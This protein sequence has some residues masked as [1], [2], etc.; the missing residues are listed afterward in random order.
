MTLQKTLFHKNKVSLAKD[1]LS[2]E[3]SAFLSGVD[4]SSLIIHAG[5]KIA[6]FADFLIQEKKLSSTITILCGKGNNGADGYSAASYL[7]KKG[8]RVQL[9]HAFD[10][11]E[12]YPLCQK[13]MQQFQKKGGHVHFISKASDIHFEKKSLIIDALLGIGFTGAL[14][15]LICEIVKK[16]NRSKETILAVDVPTGLNAN[17]GEVKT[18]AIKAYATITFTTAKKGFFLQQGY[19][20]VGKIFVEKIGLRDEFFQKIKPFAYLFNEKALLQKIPPIVRKRQKYERGSIVGIA[21]SKSMMGAAYLSGLSALR[22][23][24]GIVFVFSCD[25]VIKPPLELLT[26]ALDFKKDK[27]LLKKIQK[28]NAIFIGPGL[29]RSKEI[30][31]FLLR[32]LPKIKKPML[33]DADALY[34]LA[35]HLNEIDLKSYASMPILTP[36]HQE[37][38]R[39]L[40]QKALDDEI[41]LEQTQK[42]SQKHQVIIVLK[43][44]PTFVFHPDYLPI[45]ID[46]GDPGMATA[47]TGDVLS[48]IISSLLAQKLKPYEAA[49]LG[50]YLHDLAGEKASQIKTAHSV[51]ASDLL[52]MLPSV[53][54]D[55]SNL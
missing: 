53:F 29:G 47:G 2:I 13:Y 30:E 35:Q 16:A 24:A 34:F 55:L 41:L 46:R 4:E 5:K 11:E 20:Y 1:L 54:K 10:K 25:K 40:K 18:E 23:G 37:M 22:T 6:F 42:F 8:Y 7:L 12:T 32:V 9:Y 14:E 39:L 27:E 36:H 51:I 19:N 15:G 50:V 52:E 33:L 49:L 17:T 31:Q 44:A 45:I 21:G 43:G 48:G 26:Y 38:L 28:A 3:K